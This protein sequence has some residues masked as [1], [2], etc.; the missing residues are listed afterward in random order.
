MRNVAAWPRDTVRRGGRTSMK[1]PRTFAMTAVLAALVALPLAAQWPAGEKLDLDAVYRI[2]EEG[3]QR[4]KVMEVESYLTDVYGPRLTGSPNYNEAAAYAQKTMKEW[5]LVNVHTEPFP[6]GRS[7]QN[8][9][10]IAMAVT[11]RAYPLIGYP[12]T[13]TPGTNGPV[14]GEAVI[15]VITDESGFAEFK[16]KLRGKFVLGTAMREV[17]PHFEAPASRYSDAALADLAKQPPSGGRG[18]GR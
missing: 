1:V 12:K 14:T 18:R 17:A 6:F 10:M 8:Q 2:K 9:K 16:G 4:S 11:P 15:A 5:G 13:W 3:L 7:W